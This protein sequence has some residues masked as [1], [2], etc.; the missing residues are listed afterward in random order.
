MLQLVIDF[1]KQNFADI[2]SYVSFASALI[3][4]FCGA[5]AFLRSRINDKEAKIKGLEAQIF[6]LEERNHKISSSLQSHADD[7]N[8]I[9]KENQFNTLEGVLERYESEEREGNHHRAADIIKTFFDNEKNRLSRAAS[10]LGQWYGS[11]LDDKTMASVLPKAQGYFMIAAFFDANNEH[12]RSAINELKVFAETSDVRQGKLND[13]QNYYDELPSD[14]LNNQDDVE[15]ALDELLKKCT[16]A[17]KQGKYLTWFMLSRRAYHIAKKSLGRRHIGTLAIQYRFAKS[18]EVLGFYPEA[19][20][21]A[22]ELMAISTAVNGPSHEMTRD[23]IN[24][25][26]IIKLDMGEYE[27]ARALFNRTLEIEHK[28]SNADQAYVA[29]T[30]G[31]IAST[32]TYQ[33]EY[34]KAKPLLEKSVKLSKSTLGVNHS[35]V[36][37]GLNNLAELYRSLQMDDE[38]EP[39]L[40]EALDIKKKILTHDHPDLS[41][42]LNNLAALYSDRGEYAEAEALFLQ[43][44]AIKEQA[45][46]SQ[47]IELLTPLNN[48]A[49]ML[50]KIGKVD[51]AEKIKSRI[52]V[53]YS[54]NSFDNGY[55]RTMLNLNNQAMDY[56]NNKEHEKAEAVFKQLLHIAEKNFDH[57][58]P[59]LLATLENYLGLL[60]ESDRKNE[61]TKLIEWRKKVKANIEFNINNSR[62]NVG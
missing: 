1:W 41:N 35:V 13:T 24:L 50:R 49:I 33:G 20:V 29:T 61:A 10:I 51:D 26:A 52:D 60:L 23:A 14:D 34:S 27:E 17:H 42:S 31:N 5:W 25:T 6:A 62:K 46:G 12:W 8:R 59:A 53:I 40:V 21:N 18:L 44:I 19:L 15:A 55:L 4:G 54:K 7:L 48:Y 45:F 47:H 9:H 37:I 58:S 32:Y 36:A 39:L 2:K 30:L 3:T 22:Q 57:G 38:A 16:A 28:K 11:F 43:A 56:W